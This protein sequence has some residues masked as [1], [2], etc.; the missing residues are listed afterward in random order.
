MDTV[1]QL[2]GDIILKLKDTHPCEKHRGE[3]GEPGY[4]Y[5]APDG[6]HVGLNNRRFAIWAAAMVSLI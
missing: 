1:S 2:H 3:H 4:C 6:S 5:I